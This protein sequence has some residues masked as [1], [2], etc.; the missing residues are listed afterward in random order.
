MET[1]VRMNGFVGS[2]VDVQTTRTG[3]ARARFRLAST[4]R[5][6]RDDGQWAE[7]PTTWLSVSCWRTLAENVGRSIRKGEPV[8]VEGRLRTEEWTDA[9]GE[10][11]ENLVLEAFSVGHDLSLGTSV[12]Q[13]QRHQTSEAEADVA[14]EAEVA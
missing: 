2:D 8:F 9:E 1:I 13:R 10:R 6:R 4:P 7:Q 11:H 14:P 3:R 5:F 12:F